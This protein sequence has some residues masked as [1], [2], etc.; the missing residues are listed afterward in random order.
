MAATTAWGGAMANAKTEDTCR[1][2]R[3]YLAR[4]PSSTHF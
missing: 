2:W 1:P 4:R 3:N